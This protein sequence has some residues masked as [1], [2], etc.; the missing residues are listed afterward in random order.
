[1]SKGYRFRPLRDLLLL[2]FP[3]T[4]CG[5]GEL[6]VGDEHHL[7]TNCLMHLPETN[8]SEIVDNL[9]EQRLKGQ[10]PFVAATSLFYF[11]KGNITQHILHAVK[12]HGNIQLGRL[13]GR[14]L[15]QLLAQSHRFDDVDII[16]PTPLHWSRRWKRGFNQ[17]EIICQGIAEHLHRPVSTRHLYRSS[18]TRSQ[19]HKNRQGR[20][21]NI[22]HAFSVRHPEDYQGKHLLLVDDVITTGATTGACWEALSSIPDVRI[23]I[24]SIAITNSL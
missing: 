5:C 21:E 22:R 20:M 11:S 13:M 8:Y 14:R 12:Y 19:T 3:D 9:T 7:C 24:A 17:S 23:S 18:Y 4:C 6:L 10:I 1:M 2:F 16:V 15:G